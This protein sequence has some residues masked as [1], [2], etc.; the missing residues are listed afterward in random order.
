MANNLLSTKGKAN[1]LRKFNDYFYFG[2]FPEGVELSV[3]R[4]YLTNVLECKKR[5]II[6]RDTERQLKINGTEIEVIP[7]WKWL[8]MN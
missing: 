3:K 5:M 4:D 1:V 6:T 8:L 2:G 7:V